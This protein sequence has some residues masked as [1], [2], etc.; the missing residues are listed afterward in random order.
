MGY[1]HISN[2]YRDQRVL[3]FKEVFVLEKVH[4]TISRKAAQL[5]KA[6]LRAQIG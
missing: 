3:M 1:L 2:L 4:G 5:F 6:H